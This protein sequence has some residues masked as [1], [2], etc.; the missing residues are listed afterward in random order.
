MTIDVGAALVFLIILAIA[1]W[2]TFQIKNSTPA[3]RRTEPSAQGDG[4]Y[5][6][7]AG[8]SSSSDC[9]DSGSAGDGGCGG[10]GGGGGD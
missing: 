4:G 8:D 3:S 1:A 5:V 9:G 6:Y 2:V 10:D 7:M